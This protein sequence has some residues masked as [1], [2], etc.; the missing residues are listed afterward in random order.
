V[1]VDGV[2]PARK[3]KKRLPFLI[4]SLPIL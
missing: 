3:N 4:A 1:G 2:E